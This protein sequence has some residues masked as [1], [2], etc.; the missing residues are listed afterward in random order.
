M[1]K[2]GDYVKVKWFNIPG[3]PSNPYFRFGKVLRTIKNTDKDENV[4]IVYL[5]EYIKPYSSFYNYSS[6]ELEKDL[7]YVPK[8]IVFLEML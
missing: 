8:E 2:V 1:L 5:V 4:F 7:E 3:C 6:Y